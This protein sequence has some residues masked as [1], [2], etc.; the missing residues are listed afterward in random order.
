V[1]SCGLLQHQRRQVLKSRTGC[2][3]CDLRLLPLLCRVNKCSVPKFCH[4][5]C[6]QITS[7]PVT[8]FSKSFDKGRT[9]RRAPRSSALGTCYLGGEHVHSGGKLAVHVPLDVQP[10]Y[11]GTS[12]GYLGVQRVTMHILHHDDPSF[13][14]PLDYFLRRDT[15]RANEQLCIASNDNIHKLAE[16]TFCIIVLRVPTKVQ[17][18]RAMTG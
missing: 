7:T 9:Q 16:L 12:V 3:Q 15:D 13:M 2:L 10:C 11:D 6:A 1:G 18:S 5:P 14:Q 4:V 17:G 8:T